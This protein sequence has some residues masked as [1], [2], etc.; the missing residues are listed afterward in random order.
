MARLRTC[1]PTVRPIWA[2]SPAAWMAVVTSSVPL[3]GLAPGSGGSCVRAR[4]VVLSRSL[5]SEDAMGVLSEMAAA[6]DAQDSRPDG[7]FV[8]GSGVRVARGNSVTVVPV[9]AR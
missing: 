6:V 7:M 9:G 8:V 4:A 5:H 2:S 3:G 1:P